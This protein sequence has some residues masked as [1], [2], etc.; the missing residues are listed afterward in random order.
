MIAL[1][2]E[3]Y[4]LESR[5]VCTTVV[6]VELIHYPKETFWLVAALFIM[7]GR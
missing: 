2:A 1:Y 6:E 4:S 7:F 5:S 3:I